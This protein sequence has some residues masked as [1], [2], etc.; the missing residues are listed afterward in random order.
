MNNNY[1]H[2]NHHYFNNHSKYFL[3]FHT[4]IDITYPNSISSFTWSNFLS[5]NYISFHI[6]ILPF[7]HHFSKYH[8]NPNLNSYDIFQGYK[9]HHI[10]QIKNH[11]HNY[12]CT[13]FIYLCILLFTSFNDLS[14]DI[15]FLSV[16]LRPIRISYTYG[17]SNIFVINCQ[18]FLYL[19]LYEHCKH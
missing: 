19:N 12:I 18:P 11:N 13:L 7:F 4:D 14:H 1:D 16:S 3:N 9:H 6:I 5:H 17:H 10:T 15:V 2:H 8:H